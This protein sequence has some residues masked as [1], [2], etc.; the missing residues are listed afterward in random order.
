MDS[1]KSG[2]VAVIGIPNVGKSTLTNKIVGQKIAIISNKPQTTRNKILAIRTTKESQMIFI[3]TPGIHKPR[4]KLGEYMVNA[5]ETGLYE[6]DV[7]VF[8]TEAGREITNTEREIVEKIDESGLPAI[9]VINKI[10]GIDKTLIPKQ[11]MEYNE[12]FPFS[13]TIPLSARTGSGVDICIKEIEAILEPGP[14]FYP[15]D[16]VTDVQERTMAAEI[17]REKMLYKLEHEIPH[18]T[19]VEILDF[20]EEEKI[21]KIN[22]NIYC[23]KASHKG[24]IIGKGGEMLKSIGQAAR[25]DIEKM[26]E[27]QVYLNLWVKVKDDWRNNNYLMRSFGYEEEI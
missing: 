18:G 7:I 16:M 4:T 2:F 11:I 17:I 5:A 6:A 12:M 9:L 24:I 26:T 21:I 19:A 14:E 8:V 10:D 20:K 27:K 25:T 1:F 22:A 3:D 13:A 15:E 23:E